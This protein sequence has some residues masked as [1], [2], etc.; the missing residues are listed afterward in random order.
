MITIANCVWG[1]ICFLGVVNFFVGNGGRASIAFALPLMFGPVSYYLSL[2]QFLLQAGYRH[3]AIN[4]LIASVIGV[5]VILITFLV[6]AN[7]AKKK[8]K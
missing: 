2:H 8:S 4:I 6:L 3:P 1:I 7:Y 5:A